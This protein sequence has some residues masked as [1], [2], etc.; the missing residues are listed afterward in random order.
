MATGIESL[1][2]KKGWTPVV[3]GSGGIGVRTMK[4]GSQPGDQGYISLETARTLMKPGDTPQ[5]LMSESGQGGVDPR[6]FAS[7][8]QA[9]LPTTIAALG[10]V[11]GPAGLLQGGSAL[12]PTAA[13]GVPTVLKVAGALAPVA[14][15][16]GAGYLTGELMEGGV[17]GLAP[18]NY[19]PTTTL[20][21]TPS[22]PGVPEPPQAMVAKQWVILVHANDIGNYYIYFFKLLD[23][24]ITMYN[25][26]LQEWKIWRPKKNIVISSDPRISMINKLER[27]YNKVIRKLAKKSKALKLAR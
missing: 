27:T 1:F 6:N 20:P 10:G 26:R 2:A 7:M 17:E 12:V 21:F 25:P 13:A 19:L 3:T 8:F 23:G 22:G 11:T 24:R 9:A 15:G 5:D 4:A 14:I 18:A 16:A